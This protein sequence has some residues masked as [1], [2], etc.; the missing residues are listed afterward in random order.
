MADRPRSQIAV[1]AIS[2][3][4]AR[5]LRTLGFGRVVAAPFPNEA[6]L[7]DLLK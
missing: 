5:P 4:A 1:F 6:A 2:E 3:A 7:L